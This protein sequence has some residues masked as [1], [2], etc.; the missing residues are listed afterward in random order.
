[1]RTKV[2]HIFLFAEQKVGAFI[3]VSAFH[4]PYNAQTKQEARKFD[5]GCGSSTL[6]R[7]CT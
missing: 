6:A 4:Y 2:Y 3:I 1:M 5:Q 7:T